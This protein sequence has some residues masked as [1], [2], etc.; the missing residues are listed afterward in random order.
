V[1]VGILIVSTFLDNIAFRVEWSANDIPAYRDA[2][3]AFLAA[4][5]VG[6]VGAILALLV[7]R[8]T[9]ARQEA[10]AARLAEA[11]EAA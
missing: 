2:A 1:V 7:V 11:P 4:D 9:T 5:S 3:K 6:L 10:R 8:R